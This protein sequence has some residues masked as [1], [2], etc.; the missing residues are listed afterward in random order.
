MYIFVWMIRTTC[1]L[2]NGSYTP[3]EIITGLKPRT[4]IDCLLS[5]P[6]GAERVSTDKYVNDLVDY[7]R[8]VHKYV[9]SQHAV[10]R[11]SCQRA[12]YRELGPGGSLSLGDYCLVKKNQ[13]VG[14]SKRF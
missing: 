4:P 11:E 1:K 14:I 9:D 3:Y 13:E 2:F 5:Q 10:V 8:K 7:L 6:S 12:K